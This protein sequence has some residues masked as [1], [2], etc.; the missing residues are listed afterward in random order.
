M[1]GVGWGGVGGALLGLSVFCVF[2]LFLCSSVLPFFS[3]S[4]VS[5]SLC[6]LRE[7]FL[8]SFLCN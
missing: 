3:Y 6:L 8:S 2:G 4:F 5:F 7:D 1:C